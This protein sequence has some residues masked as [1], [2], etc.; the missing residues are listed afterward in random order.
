MKNVSDS[1]LFR[2][3]RALLRLAEAAA[4]A[5]AAGVDRW[6]YAVTL[7]EMHNHA[8][9]TADVHWLIGERLAERRIETTRAGANKRTFRR[10]AA[11]NGAKLAVVLTD[12]GLR[13]SQRVVEAA[14]Q[15]STARAAVPQWDP[16][17]GNLTLKGDLVKHAVASAVAQRTILQACQEQGWSRLIENPYAEMPPRRR[18]RFLSRLLSELNGHQQDC[19][20]HFY[21]ARDKG[22]HFRWEA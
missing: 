15:T 12:A 11:T 3:L 10:T 6:R 13:I 7:D 8:V 19:R 2:R 22:L 4:E 1:A 20:V 14:T 21:S 18:S 9:L 16:E 17:T 5:D